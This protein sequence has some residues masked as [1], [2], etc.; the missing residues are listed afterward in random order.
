[1]ILITPR[2]EVD[3]ASPY[4]GR[5]IV[6]FPEDSDCEM[7]SVPL[8]LTQDLIDTWPAYVLSFFPVF[9]TQR[10]RRNNDIRSI[11][12]CTM[13]V[14]FRVQGLVCASLDPSG[15]TPS[16]I[17]SDY[18]GRPVHLVVKGPQ[19]RACPPTHAFPDLAASSVFQDAYPFLV[20]S[21]ESLG[22]VGRV[23]GAFACD[24][25]PENKV[26]GLDRAKWRDGEVTIER[27]VG[28]AAASAA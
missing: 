22:A 3:T 4:G 9:P 12:D 13:H 25:A 28:L 10:L 15:R 2:I 23:V 21:E 16:A 8:N 5:L 1:M 24:D 26:G 27:C 20:A 14:Q 19:R 17:L 7:F 18:F 6:A 11:D